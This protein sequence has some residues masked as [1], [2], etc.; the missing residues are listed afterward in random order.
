MRLGM[1][2]TATQLL[3]GPSIFSGRLMVRSL[4]HFDFAAASPSFATAWD[5]S[6]DTRS[7]RKRGAQPSINS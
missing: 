5:F 6:I 4:A 2:Q 3:E 1:R 7:T